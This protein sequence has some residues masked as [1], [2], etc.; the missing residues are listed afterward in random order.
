MNFWHRV[1]RTLCLLAHSHSRLIIISLKFHT[2]HMWAWFLFFVNQMRYRLPFLL[3][4]ISMLLLSPTPHPTVFIHYLIHITWHSVELY[5]SFFVGHGQSRLHSEAA[6]PS[7]GVWGEMWLV[8]YMYGLNPHLPW[9]QKFRRGKHDF[10]PLS[11]FSWCWSLMLSGIVNFITSPLL[12]WP[13]EVQVYI[14]WA[15]CI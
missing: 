7:Q 4:L 3:S 9:S 14:I 13:L 12:K 11:T 6:W 10:C 2:L 15:I 5:C 1:I 8:L